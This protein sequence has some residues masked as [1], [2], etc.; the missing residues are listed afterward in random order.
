MVDHVRGLSGDGGI[1]DARN[2][3]GSA[4]SHKG[5]STSHHTCA[6]TGFPAPR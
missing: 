5:I 2:I 4:L 1:S 6:S 3:A